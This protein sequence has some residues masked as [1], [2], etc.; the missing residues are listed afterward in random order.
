MLIPSDDIVALLEEHGWAQ[1]A[2]V[3]DSG[4]LCHL[5]AL[6]AAT[7]ADGYLVEQVWHR[8]GRGTDWNDQATWDEVVGFIRTAQVTDADL[9][10]VFGPQWAQVRRI[11]HRAALFNAR[12]RKRIA[13]A[14]ADRPID[15]NGR[16]WRL[17]R[18]I[19]DTPERLLWDAAMNAASAA[20]DDA[21]P[22]DYIEDCAWLAGVTAAVVAIGHVVDPDDKTVLLTPWN[23]AIT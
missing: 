10:W 6:R 9:E 3:D 22:F 7:G 12:D 21:M 23:A 5:T 16:F 2:A 19:D 15:W 13:A 14:L 1:G 11:V 17:R 18:R 20:A 8:I 4:G